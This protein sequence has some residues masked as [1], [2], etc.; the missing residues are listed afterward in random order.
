[1]EVEQ[2]STKTAKR[3]AEAHLIAAGRLKEKYAGRGPLK[4][5]CSKLRLKIARDQSKSERRR[6]R[7]AALRAWAYRQ[8]EAE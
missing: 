7:R 3:L 4:M 2:V 6:R 5:L 1:M 8:L